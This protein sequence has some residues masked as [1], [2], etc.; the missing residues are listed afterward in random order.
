M[1]ILMK[2][3][4]IFNI[5]WDDPEEAEGL[6]IGC[7]TLWNKLNYKRRESFFD[8]DKEFDWSSDE[9]YDEFKGWIGSA[10]AQQIVRKNNSAWKSYFSLLKKWKNN[11]EDM[12]KPS[13]PGY[14]KDRKKDEKELK[15]LVRNDCYEIEDDGTIKLP[16]GR[17]GKIKGEP[18]WDGKQGRLEIVYDRL[19][20]RWRAFQ[21]VEVEPRHQP[22]GDKS[23]Y[24]DLGVIYPVMTYIEGGETTVGYSGRPL[25]SDWWLYNKRIDKA[26][27]QAKEENDRYTS[28]RIKRLFRQRKRKFK[29]AVRKIAHDFIERCYQAG[30]DNVV[31]GDLT[32]IRDKEKWNS[33]ADSMIHNYWSHKYLTDR[34]RWTAENYGIEIDLIDERGTS[35]KCPKCGSEK[36]V[37]RGRL[38]KCKECGIEANR[39]SVGA[40]NIGLAQGGNIPAEVI[41]IYW[42]IR[43]IFHRFTE[44]Y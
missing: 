2:R 31:M 4:N 5:E 23:A 18:H 20:D 30:V 28:E 10:T 8:N 40:L 6:G 13:P 19:D 43:W 12:E 1:M 15:I 11:G 38:F 24:V 14:W 16:L 7:S 33:K 34:I 21:S 3:T 37:R 36:K 26:K 22:R 29:D 27:S 44:F 42:K 25:L 9:L 35:S 41:N 17:T 32:G 39:D